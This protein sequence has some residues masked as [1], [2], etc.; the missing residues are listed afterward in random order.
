[1]PLAQ[2]VALAARLTGAKKNALYRFGL[3]LALG[4][5]SDAAPASDEDG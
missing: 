1:L 3:G 5:P 4:Q 2:A